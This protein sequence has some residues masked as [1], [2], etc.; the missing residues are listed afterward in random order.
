[1]QRGEKGSI[2]KNISVAQFKVAKEQKRGEKLSQEND[3][4]EENLTV[5]EDSLVEVTNKAVKIKSIDEIQEKTVLIGNKVAVDKDEFE[6]V[7]T[8][9]K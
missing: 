2:E 9:A 1:M 8:L 7:K 4:L 3:K 6:E 5:L